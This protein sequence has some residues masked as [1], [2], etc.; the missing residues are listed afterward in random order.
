MLGPTNRDP[1]QNAVPN[2]QYSDAAP[3]IALVPKLS[4]LNKRPPRIGKQRWNRLAV[5]FVKGVPCWNT[6]PGLKLMRA[7]EVM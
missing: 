6:Q 7:A 3:K 4:P 1:G 5:Q 2:H